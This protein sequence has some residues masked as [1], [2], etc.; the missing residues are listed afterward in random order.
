MLLAIST[1][2][3]S[4]NVIEAIQAAHERN[5]RVVALT[6]NEG[7]KIAS[8]AETRPIS[9]FAFRLIALHAFRKYIC[10]PCTVC[11]TPSITYL[12]GE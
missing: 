5:M 9:I 12:G 6:G 10:S 7:G 3:N 8:H 2:G 11:V 1:S 4:P